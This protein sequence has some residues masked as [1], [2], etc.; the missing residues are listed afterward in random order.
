MIL[1]IYYEESPLSIR[2]NTSRSGIDL[3]FELIVLSSQEELVR[4]L[5]HRTIAIT[6]PND[7][8]DDL[9]ATSRTTRS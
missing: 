6:M 1:M 2:V 5:Q 4:P 7:F 8:P 3:V 9:E